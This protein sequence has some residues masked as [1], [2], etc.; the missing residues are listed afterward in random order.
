MDGELDPRL[1][2]PDQVEADEESAANLRQMAALLGTFWDACKAVGL[3]DSLS[4]AVVRDWHQA[5]ITDGV[6]WE[7]DDEG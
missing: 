1:V 3:P 5:V 2:D 7:S 4:A 6:A